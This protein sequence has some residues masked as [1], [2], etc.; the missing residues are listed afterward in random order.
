[1][2][3]FVILPLFVTEVAKSIRSLAWARPNGPV[4]GITRTLRAVSTGLRGEADPLTRD[5]RDQPV[6]AR[7][8]G[9]QIAAAQ[10]PV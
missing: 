9:G 2:A 3:S 7:G 6:P 5:L 10:A 1:M 4:L 8:S